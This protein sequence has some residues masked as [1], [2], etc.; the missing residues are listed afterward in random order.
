MRFNGRG[1]GLSDE[2]FRPQMQE[3][4]DA[5]GEAVLEDGREPLACLPL[6]LGERVGL[7]ERAYERLLEHDVAAGQ[8]GLPPLLEMQR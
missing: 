6:K 7:G 8:E 3:L 4:R 5:V 1:I 2:A